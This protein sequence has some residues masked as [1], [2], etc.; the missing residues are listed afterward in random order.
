MSS[1]TEDKGYLAPMKSWWNAG[2]P[3]NFNESRDYYY[4]IPLNDL[5][6]NRNL[7][8]NPGWDEVKG[9]E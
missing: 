5:S 1:F 3:F 2:N 4:P 8:Q 6:L 7:I 9:S